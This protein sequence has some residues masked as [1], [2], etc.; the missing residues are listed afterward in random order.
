[1]KNQN[2][3]VAIPSYKRAGKQESLEYMSRN[4]VP[5]SRLYIFVQT[6]E[7]YQDYMIYSDKAQIIYA[8]A[9]GVAAAR[10]NILRF[11]GGKENILMLDDDI[12]TF[13]ILKNGKIEVVEGEK[14]LSELIT[15]C[16]ETARKAKAPVFGFYPV[17]N[18]FFMSNSIS[19]KVT[20]NTV[21]GFTA[22]N[23]I[24]LDESYRAKEDIELCARLLSYGKNILR[25]NFLAP[26]AKHRTNKGGCSDLWK[27]DA[28]IDTVKRLCITYPYVLAPHAT[29]SNE[30]RVILKD[31]KIKL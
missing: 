28:N 4:G 22:G 27:G 10:N 8:K 6:P 3:V 1:M 2:Y 9:D 20:V 5:K 25:F 23:L 15:R 17:Y 7:D 14:E 24:F 26:K 19:T 12:S 16:F 30:V 21:L 18:D 31:K 13:G 11:F 29:K